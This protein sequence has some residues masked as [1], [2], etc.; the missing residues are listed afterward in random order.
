MNT[1]TCRS[2]L[3]AGNGRAGY[4][5]KVGK[6]RPLFNSKIE[7]S[8]VTAQPNYPHSIHVVEYLLGQIP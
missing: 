8:G 6:G 2:G 5:G 7:L 1:A 4:V 3:L